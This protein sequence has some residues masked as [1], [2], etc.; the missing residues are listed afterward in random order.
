MITIFRKIGNWLDRLEEEHN[1][2]VATERYEREERARKQIAENAR[3]ARLEAERIEKERQDHIKDVLGNKSKWHQY[4]KDSN[5][6]IKELKEEIRLLHDE[7]SELYDR[8][9]SLHREMD[10][11]KVSRSA[12]IRES[13][14]D[15]D[16][17]FFWQ[18]GVTNKRYQRNHS[19]KSYH[20][21]TARFLKDEMNVVGGKINSVKYDIDEIK[22][23]IV[24][25]KQMIDEIMTRRKGVKEILFKK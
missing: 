6:Q 20:G 5:E 16:D 12:S 18:S 25:R 7:K 4:L 3:Q 9:Q 8:K 10:D 17:S 11:L 24:A 13:Q 15:A 22:S 19:T 23:S 2:R 1:R 21:D 14:R